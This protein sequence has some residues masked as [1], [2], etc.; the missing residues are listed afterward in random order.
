LSLEKQV[1][2][3]PAQI[4]SVLTQWIVDEYHQAP[5]R[6]LGEKTPQEVWESQAAMYVI[7]PANEDELR[8]QQGEFVYR[9][10]S[11]SASEAGIVNNKI[12]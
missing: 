2:Y 1:C 12:K 8:L 10:I 3:T 4:E 5:H 7:L 9:T 6:G 11:G